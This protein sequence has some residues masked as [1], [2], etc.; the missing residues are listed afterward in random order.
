MPFVLSGGKT[1]RRLGYATS[2]DNGGPTPVSGT[3]RRP[4]QKPHPAAP[5][6]FFVHNDLGGMRSC[7]AGA[8]EMTPM[9]FPP[10]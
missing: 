6:G 8:W 3:H 9:V 2:H 4:R 10:T 5:A 7:M 1:I